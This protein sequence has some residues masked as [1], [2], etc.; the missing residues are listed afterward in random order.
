M[1]N[2]MTDMLFDLEGDFLP[3]GYAFHLWNA[4]V[5]I[6]PWIEDTTHAGILPL[7]GSLNGR[8]LL[9]PK[10]AKLGLRI[11]LDCSEKALDLTGKTLVIGDSSVKIGKG[12]KKPIEAYPTLHS[13]FVESGKEETDFLE[14]VAETLEGMGIAGKCIC[15]RSQR[16]KL[17][18]EPL[19]G[20]SLVVHDLKPSGSIG[21]QQSGLGKHRRYGCGLFVPHKTISG[22]E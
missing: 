1:E 12:A 3:E 15:G 18:N 11:P 14:D 7:K 9:L 20:Y 2:E 19:A 16:M 17:G 21:L 4:I 5:N 8:I 22:L 10:R 13:H 6:L